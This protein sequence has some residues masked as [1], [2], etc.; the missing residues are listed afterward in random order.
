[1]TPAAIPQVE[2][3]LVPECPHADAARAVLREAIAALGLDIEV[4]ERVGDF[5]SPTV[6]ADGIDVMT[7]LAAVAG[8]ACRLDLP[9]AARVGQALTAGPGT[10]QVPYPAELAVGVTR[11][12]ISTV[13]AAARTV[14]K[15]ILG[16]FAAH[17]H[18]PSRAELSGSRVSGA[19]LDGLL[20]ELHDKDVI[21]L[22]ADGAIRAAYPFSG[23]P[24]AHVVAVDGGRAV[25]AMCAIDALGIARM[26]GRDVTITSRDPYTG[27]NVTVSIQDGQ[28]QWEPASTVVFVGSD[29]N[30]AVAGRTG[31]CCPPEGESCSAAAADRCCGVMNFFASTT[32]AQDWWQANPAAAGHV[33]TQAQ[34]LQ[35]GNDIFGD[36]L[37]S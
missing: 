18:A 20:D 21:R 36:L 27:A 28:P 16:W 35:L 31:D 11:D 5:P 13:S 22:D 8:A 15:Q 30:T 2:L 12:R 23:V 17:G 9:T 1:M 25:Y 3:L 10:G 33:L 34:A 32:S 19:E 24:T 7:G 26:L 37:H 14:H 6:L 29:T 4:T